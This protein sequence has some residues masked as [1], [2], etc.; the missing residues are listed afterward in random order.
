MSSNIQSVQNLVLN[1]TAGATVF[2]AGS[3]Q[4]AGTATITVTDD[5][6]KVL[7]SVQG[8][9]IQKFLNPVVFVTPTANVRVTIASGTNAQSGMVQDINVVNNG[10]NY[11][12]GYTIITE[13]ST[14]ADY[15]DITL[16]L[17]SNWKNG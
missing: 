15:N 10:T 17:W 8:T 6:G 7:A 3:A 12:T 16:Q 14:D 13:D 9:G 4:T 2:L 1:F 11:L 5:N